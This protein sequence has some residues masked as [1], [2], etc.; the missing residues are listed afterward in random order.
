MNCCD[1]SNAGVNETMDCKFDSSIVY[2]MAIING[3]R[4]CSPRL[5]RAK[6]YKKYDIC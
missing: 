2:C 3:F 6:A 5:E 1:Y 4:Y